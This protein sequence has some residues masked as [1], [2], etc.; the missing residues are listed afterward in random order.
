MTERI[1]GAIAMASFVVAMF[2]L[3]FWKRTGDR[4][5]L[6]FGIAFL[7][8][9]LDRAVLEPLIHGNSEYEPTIYIGRLITFALIAL[10]IIDKNRRPRIG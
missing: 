1:L 9:A 5:F 7:V 10:A 8:D 2:F 6:I 4:F 3:R